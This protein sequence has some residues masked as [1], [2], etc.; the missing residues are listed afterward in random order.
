[1]FLFRLG[2]L[3][4]HLQRPGKDRLDV[5]LSLLVVR[6]PLLVFLKSLVVRRT[7]LM[8]SVDIRPVQG[9]LSLLS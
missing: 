4:L 6:Q 9:Q 5:G 7:S 2:Q 8:Y 1:M 3:L